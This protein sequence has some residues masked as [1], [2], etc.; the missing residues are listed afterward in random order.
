MFGID[1]KLA[2]RKML[3]RKFKNGVYY[4]LNETMNILWYFSGSFYLGGWDSNLPTEGQK[5]G[6]GFEYIPEKYCYLGEFKD[7]VKHGQGSIQ[8]TSSNADAP[9]LTMCYEGAWEKGKPHGF[10]K[11]IDERDTRYI[12]TFLAGEKT[13]SATILTKE[14]LYYEG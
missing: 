1:A 5:Q 11:H 8:L 13:G 6:F 2:P 12:G 14:G 9:E 3:S 4:H 7:G 10:G